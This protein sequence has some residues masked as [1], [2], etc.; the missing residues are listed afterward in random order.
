MT[1]EQKCPDCG[2]D[3]GTPHH[4]ECDVERCSVCGQQ[5]IT[6]GCADHD[7]M[8]ATWTGEWPSIEPTY[9]GI[10]ILAR[11]DPNGPYSES[12]CYFRTAVS[13]EEARQG[14][15]LHVGADLRDRVLELE[16]QGWVEL[17]DDKRQE[18]MQL[19]EVKQ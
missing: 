1:L 14:V 19:E 7:R 3:I 13:E 6:C 12:N 8:K 9:L 18:L 4:N 17:A 11:R 16:R 2:A 10:A 15:E 5:R